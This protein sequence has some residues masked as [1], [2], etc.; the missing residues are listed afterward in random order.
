MKHLKYILLVAA[1]A[2]SFIGCN[3][4]IDVSFESS[5]QEI[6]AQGGSIELGLKS[7]G[8]WTINS[9]AEWLSVSPLSGNGDATLTITAEANPTEEPRMAI[10]RATTKDSASTLTLTQAG[11]DPEKYVNV[12]PQEILCDSEGGEYVIVLSSNVDWFT[13]APDWISCSPSEGSGDARITLTVS[14]V[15]GDLA[16]SREAEVFFGNLAV[17]DKVHVVQTVEPVLS[18]DI[19]PNNLI[20]ACTGETKNVTVTTEDGWTATVE[21][22]WVTLSQTEG[23]GD[24]EISVTVD[25]NPIYAD[26]AAIV[27]FTTT[28]GV[29]AVLTIRQEASPDPHFLEVSPLEISFGKEGGEHDITIGC[30]IEWEF[31]F[32]CEWLSLSQRSGTGN[33]TVVLTAEPNLMTETRAYEFLIK[34]RELFYLITV[35]QA[36]GDIPVVADFEPDSLFLAYTGGLQH[37]QLTSSTSWI[38]QADEWI[39]LI[40][41]T[42][43][44]GDASF[45]IIVDSNTDPVDRIGFVRA[46]HAGQTLATL[47]IVQEGKIDF[48]ETDI[49]QI[50]VRP[51]GGSYDIQVSSNMEWKV[52]VNDD[53]LRCDPLGGFANGSFNI[54]VDPMPSPRPRI[55]YVKVVG[56]SGLEVK[57]TIDQH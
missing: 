12:T 52:I 47:V 43:G 22:S 55:G 56:E 50:D 6:D 14:P 37:V 57:I 1:V 34:S 4:T 32:D 27:H 11:S 45:D 35:N 28:G 18:I 16:E 51:E 49:T 42:S 15:D 30:D 17:S 19:T 24:A 8:D 21:D 29:Q 25:E 54:T 2:L 7:N 31:D 23:Q 5:T 40:T 26:R 41:T 33:A 46:I 13:S 3:K 10:V 48:L 44:E 38:L 20:M 53:W 9:T 36:P 39:T